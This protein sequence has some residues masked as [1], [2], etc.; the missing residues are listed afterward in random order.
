[1]SGSVRAAACSFIVESFEVIESKS[2]PKCFVLADFFI[3]E[4]YLL[5][6]L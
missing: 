1:M 5:G 4:I 2:Q 6:G 3:S